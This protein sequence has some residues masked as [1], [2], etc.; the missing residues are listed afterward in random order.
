MLLESINR[1]Y[2]YLLSH[3]LHFNIN[4]LDNYA[5]LKLVISKDM[6]VIRLGDGELALIR[7]ESIPY[8]KYDPTLASKL[9]SLLMKG[10]DSKI[11]VCLP[12]VFENIDRYN[13]K[14]R[15]FY[16]EYFFFQ[17]KKLLR[18]VEN[19]NNFY[20]STFISRPYIDL[21]EKQNASKYFSE[22]KKLWQDKNVLIVEGRASRSGEGND[23]FS[24]VRS[25]KR[26]IAPST[27]A[28]FK[29]NDIEKSILKYAQD[30]L[31][32]L[33]LGPTSKVIVDELKN[34]QNI[35][36]QI[37]DLGH[38]DSEYEWFKMGVTKKVRIPNKHTAEFSYDE[39]NVGI[40]EDKKYNKEIID[41]IN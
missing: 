4:V 31:I 39:D 13:E 3:L 33:M 15:K 36:N 2:H 16:Y 29:I 35:K 21:K 40:V 37:I 10:T 22:L 25:L 18:A 28:Y 8:Q 9:N 24:N 12:D 5:S 14:A 20:G 27:N 34:A 7:G 19:K 1:K 11:L 23:L 6:S 30:R 26:I 41:L 38:I 32:L 17:N